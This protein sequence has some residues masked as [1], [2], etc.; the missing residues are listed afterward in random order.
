MDQQAKEQAFMSALVTEHFVQQSA[1]SATIS[2]SSSRASLYL[3]SLS[4]SLVALGFATQSRQAFPYFAAGVL[5]AIFVLGIFSFVRVT[6]TA[7]ANLN[8]LQAIVRIRHYYAGLLPEAEKFFGQRDAEDDAATALTFLGTT[9]SS[10]NVL[11][12]MAST[13]AA[14]NSIVA[15]VG[16]V[17]LVVAIFGVGSLGLAVAIGAVLVILL[18]VAAVAYQLRRFEQMVAGRR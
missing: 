16:V 6:D 3:L 4:S 12:S 10:I 9:R 1:A 14:I 15:G 17:I 2:E 18:M 13:L 5:P 8:S 7:M 11:F